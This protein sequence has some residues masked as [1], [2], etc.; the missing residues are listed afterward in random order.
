MMTEGINTYNQLEIEFEH[1]N[2]K[3]FKKKHTDQVLIEN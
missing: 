2:I 3:T 1:I